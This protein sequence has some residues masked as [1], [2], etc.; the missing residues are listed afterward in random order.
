MTAGVETNP[1]AI[2]PELTESQPD[3][4]SSLGLGTRGTNPLRIGIAMLWL[5]VM[6][7]LPLAAI[8]WQSAKGGWSAFVAAVTSPSAIDSFLV[9][10]TISAAV[11]VI[12]VIFGVLVAWVLVRDDFP[13]KRL[14]DAVMDEASFFELHPDFARSIVVGLPRTGTSK[15][16]RMMASDPGAQRLEVWRLL[17]PAP[18]PRETELGTGGRLMFAQVVEKTIAQMFPDFMARH[19]RVWRRR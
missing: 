16:Q 19:P 1:E 3:G 8:V 7:L 6:V 5:S 15:L 2:R 10:L 18:F 12:N 14:I 13:G 11:T 17:N 4:R 9:T